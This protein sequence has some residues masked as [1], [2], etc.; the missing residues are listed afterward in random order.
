MSQGERL[1]KVINILL[2]SPKSFADSLGLPSPTTIY[3][4]LKNRREITPGLAKIINE[5]YPDLDPEWLLNGTGEMYTWKNKPEKTRELQEGNFLYNKKC[6]ECIKKDE[7]ILRLTSELL[8][9]QKQYIEC[10]KEVSVLKNA[11]LG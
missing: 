3:D 7:E 9:M 5:T 2:E 10:L 1:K 11:A 4:V 6:L 8:I